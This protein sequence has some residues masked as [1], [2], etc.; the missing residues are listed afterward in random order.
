MLYVML[1]FVVVGF[2]LDRWLAYLNDKNWTA[3]LPAEFEGFYSKDKYQKARNYDKDHDKL[4]VISGTIQFILT[5]IIL[6]FGWFGILD[7][8][9]ASFEFS[10]Y[11]HVL[12]FFGVIMLASSVM[13]LPFNIYNTFVLEEK[14]GF[15]K[16]TLKTFIL[17]KIKGTI[18]SAV[19]G[20][21]MLYLFIWFYDETG[22][23]FWLYAWITSTSFSLFFATFYTSIIVPI[24][25]K[26]T[27][28]EEGSLRNKIEAFSKKVQ[29]KLDNIYVMDGSK[30]SAKSNAYFS[31][32]GAT[33]KI[34]LFDTL[35]EQQDEEE[36][37]AVLAH[38]IGHYKHKHIYKSMFFGIFQMGI[39]F[40]LLGLFIGNEA[41]SQ[42]LGG[43]QSSF[44][45]GLIGFMIL[46]SPINLLSGIF[47]SWY[48]RKNEFE[49]DAYAVTNYV[50]ESL[51]TALKKLT[52]DNLGNLSPHPYVVWLTYSHPTVL[53]RIERIR[54]LNANE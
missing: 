11:L 40:Y 20:S 21:L 7:A 43:Q 34:V 33:K 47:S 19:L 9:I 25:N 27:P 37:V 35:I 14:Y 38:E 17:D 41:I 30:R 18:L 23:K 12:F 50:P 6:Y 54:N 22:D 32:L 13:N 39:I 31:G 53:Q 15:N 52:V 3:Q 8:Y 46:L 51:I 5:L 48:S 1:F 45:L 36:I 44:H 10:H 26:L 49:A 24:F 29:F 16:T 2:V 28:L 42:A 4:G